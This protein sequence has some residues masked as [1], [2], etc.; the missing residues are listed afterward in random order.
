LRVK[1]TD[2]PAFK[3]KMDPSTCRNRYRAALLGTRK[4]GAH[5]AVRARPVVTDR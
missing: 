3:G 4:G 5:A 1:P 2:P